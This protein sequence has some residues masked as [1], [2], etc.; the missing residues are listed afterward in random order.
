[1]PKFEKVDD[2]QM[3]VTREVS[4]MIDIP[5]LVLARKQLKEEQ[6]ALQDQ[7]NHIEEAINEAKKLGMDISV[8]PKLSKGKNTS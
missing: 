8:K 5:K 1:M 2:R 3:R 4:S 6:K 7:L